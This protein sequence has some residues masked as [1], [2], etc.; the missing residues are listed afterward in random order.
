T[1]GFGETVCGRQPRR[2]RDA[3]E[4]MDMNLKLPSWLGGKKGPD[5]EAQTQLDLN[6]TRPLSTVTAAQPG[7]DPLQTVAIMEGMRR[8]ASS[9]KEPG[10]LPLIGRLPIAKQ[11]QY[12]VIAA[13]AFMALSVIMVVVDSSV[14][15][16]IAASSGTATEMQM[17][18]QR[19]A[20]GV[21][22][23]VLGNKSGFAQVK[24]STAKFREDL[25]ALTKGGTAR[26]TDVSP[27]NSESIRTMLDAINSRW[28]KMESAAKLILANEAS[29]TTLS[30]GVDNINQGNSPL[31]ELTEQGATQLA[32]A[33]GSVKEVAFA[34]QLVMLTQRIAKNAN[35]LT[36]GDEIDPEV[37]FLL[38]K[39]V[40]TFREVL[41]GLLKG[42]DTLRLAGV[43]DPETKQTLT[44]LQKRFQDY[45]TRVNAI[46]QN[47]QK[48][49][50]AKQAAR[51]V[52]QESEPLL[53]NSI[54][55]TEEYDA[56]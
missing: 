56:N 53:Q 34:N 44:D 25:N 52:N 42:S 36:S 6:P 5:P 1:T 9:V 19:L 33:G 21:T 8:D 13:V 20:R 41:Q 49:V 17:L 35:T 24:D 30:S 18:S 26:S 16:R 47:M 3:E 46:L 54:K 15:G 38:G 50:A 7:Y 40:G 28:D 32:Q 48:L 11:F 12:L 2:V 45:E 43:K 51:F 37:A 10:R 29:L 4:G 23:T 39:D 27:S 31:L 22:L 55:L 14:A